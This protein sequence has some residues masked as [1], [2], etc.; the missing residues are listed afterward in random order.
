MQLDAG[1]GAAAGSDSGPRPHIVLVA[2][3]LPWEVPST[4]LAS[5]LRAFVLFLCVLT[6]ALASLLLMTVA[7]VSRAEC[8]RDDVLAVTNQRA[9]G[10]CMARCLGPQQNGL[11]T[12]DLCIVGV[13]DANVVNVENCLWRIRCNL[14]SDGFCCGFRGAKGARVCSVQPPGRSR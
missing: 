8:Q 12:W 7:F 4:S 9:L 5:E 14:Q 11:P 13:V 1:S 2:R 6:P 10:R 3:D